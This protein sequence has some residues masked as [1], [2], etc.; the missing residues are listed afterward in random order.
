[1]NLG[2]LFR[3]SLLRSLGKYSYAMYVFQ[4]PLIPLVAMLPSSM[5]VFERFGGDDS[6]I[7][8][9]CYIA[10]MFLLTYGIALLSWHILEKHCLRLKRH[11]KVA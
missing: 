5:S 9:L 4:S 8:H 6:I 7:A 3:S 1:M 2:R 10:F 11:F